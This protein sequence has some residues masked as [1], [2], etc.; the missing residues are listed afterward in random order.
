[1]KMIPR[2]STFFVLAVVPFVLL[3]G[4][5]AEKKAPPGQYVVYVGTYTTK[6]ESKGINAFRFD[7]AIGKMTAAHLAVESP[8]PSFVAVHSSGKY[9]YAVNE[10][11]NSSMVSAFAVDAA[12]AKSNSTWKKSWGRWTATSQ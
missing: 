3:L 2:V 6:T 1:M 12:M 10:A 7:A 11:G 4:N 5:A 8:D 9:L